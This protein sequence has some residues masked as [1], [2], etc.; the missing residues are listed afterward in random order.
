MRKGKHLRKILLL[1]WAVLMPV[2]LAVAQ[3]ALQ[4]RVSVNLNSVTINKLFDEVKKQA[5]VSFIY[6]SDEIRSLPRITVNE[7]NQTVRNVLDRAMQQINC[8]Y[9]VNGNVVT[10]LP[11]KGT[12]GKRTISGYV[13]DEAGE[14]LPGVGI[15]LNSDKIAAVTDAEGRYTMD[16]KNVEGG[17]GTT[18][19]QMQ[20]VD[21]EEHGGT[22]KKKVV[23]IDA[24]EVKLVAPGHGAWDMGTFAI[25]QDVSLEKE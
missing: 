14:P 8:N 7:T 1:C 25:K 23:L 9:R 18:G 15:R 4:K 12:S 13:R 22:F 11:V 6:N 5:G 21:G 17:I 24:S 16:V 10:L 20:D 3:S 2:Q 19:L